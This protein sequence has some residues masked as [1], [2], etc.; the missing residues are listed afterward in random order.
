MAKIQT[1]DPIDLNTISKA[2]AKVGDFKWSRLD[3]SNFGNEHLGTWLLCNGQTASGTEYQTL[4]GE[5]NVPDAISDGTFLRQAKAGRNLG[6]YEADEN[7]SHSHG[8]DTSGYGTIHQLQSHIAAWG[9]HAGQGGGELSTRD[10]TSSAPI[11]INSQ[12]SEA[13]PKNLAL[14]LFVKVG[15]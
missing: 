9:P 12:G 4:T 10:G 13:R 11:S 8:I 14:N 6:S 5:S 1:G 15:Y 7:K 3:V 2:E